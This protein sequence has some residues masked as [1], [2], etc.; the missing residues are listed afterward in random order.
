MSWTFSMCW[1]VITWKNGYCCLVQYVELS[2]W[3]FYSLLLCPPPSLHRQHY[4]VYMLIHGHHIHICNSI[5]PPCTQTNTT[6]CKFPKCKC[7]ICASGWKEKHHQH[8]LQKLIPPCVQVQCLCQR[9]R[10]K[11]QRYQRKLKWDAATTCN[12]NHHHHHWPAQ[13]GSAHRCHWSAQSSNHC[14]LCK[15]NKWKETMCY[16]NIYYRCVL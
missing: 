11:V 2:P 9:L 15:G 14:N 10:Y 4:R 8:K 7:S 5:P 12:S 13:A 16:Y 1:H 6:Q 3:Q